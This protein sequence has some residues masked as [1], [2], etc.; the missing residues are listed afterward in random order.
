MA[1][2]LLGGD[3][4]KTITDPAGL[5]KSGTGISLP[6]GNLFFGARG[7][8][9]MGKSM[10]DKMAKPDMPEYGM[11]DQRGIPMMKKM[12]AEGKMG[13]EQIQQ[14]AFEGVEEAGRGGLIDMSQE[15]QLQA[16]RAGGLLPAGTQEA[17]AQTARRDV[18]KELARKKRAFS[19]EI[20]GIHFLL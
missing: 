9:G 5:V 20:P 19:T 1:K 7:A 8:L 11:T 15:Q 6:G 4:S 17:M 10:L 16:A 12:Y 13:P 2:G 14:R 18:G 3:L